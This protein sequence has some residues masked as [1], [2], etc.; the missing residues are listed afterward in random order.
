[1]A[2]IAATARRRALALFLA[3]A[4]G[5]TACASGSDSGPTDATTPTF[6]DSE[7]EDEESGAPADGS[8]KTGGALESGSRVKLGESVLAKTLD[9]ANQANSGRF[10][11][12]LDMERTGDDGEPVTMSITFEGAYDI[13]AKATSMTMDMSGMAAA[14][15][16]IRR[17]PGWATSWGSP[18]S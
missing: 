1:M 7:G 18:C 14:R 11:G 9:P 5:A 8:T 13:A 4:M 17:P 10:T 2:M 12:T 6:N 15:V 3:L 16:P